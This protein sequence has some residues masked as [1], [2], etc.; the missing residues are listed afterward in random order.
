MLIS[1]VTADEQQ[2]CFCWDGNTVLSG[3][4]SGDLLVWDIMA[5]KVTDRIP[6]I[7]VL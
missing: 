6:G 5:A 4:Q 7:Q 3:G 2:R 1:T